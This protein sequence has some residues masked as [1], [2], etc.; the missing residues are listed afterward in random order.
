MKRYLT[1]LITI[2]SVTVIAPAAFSDTGEGS[3]IVTD[4][5]SL[6]GGAG[7]GE[8]GAGSSEAGPDEAGEADEAGPDEDAGL[9]EELFGEASGGDTPFIQEGESTSGIESALLV[10]DGVELGGRY[11]FSASS[12]WEW[13]EP[14][15]LL[16]DLTDP[17]I[18]PADVDFSPTGSAA[19]DLNATLFFD[20]RPSEDFRV[21]GKTSITHPFED[22]DGARSFDEVFHIE[23]L[24]SDFSLN[25]A[26]F[27]RGGKHTIN[28]GVGYF[29]SPAD[30]LNITEIDPE[31]PEADREGPV[32][33]KAQYPFGA[34]NAYLYGIANRVDEPDEFGVAAKVELVFGS[35]EFGAGGL[36]QK[37]IAP[38]AMLTV[39]A[40]LAD[41]DLFAEAVFR[42][43]SDRTFV[44]ESNAPEAGYE[45]VTYDDEL[46]FNATLGFSF[47]HT[48]DEVS[49]SINL[50]G[51]YLFN[52]EGYDDPSIIKEYLG[53]AAAAMLVD[54]D[55]EI[56]LTVSDMRQTG[57][58]YTAL[59]G[60]WNSIFGSDFSFQ[61]LWMH[62][63]SDSSG[64]FSPSISMAPFDQL[65]ISLKTPYRYGDGG[66]EYSPAGESVSIHLSANL[67][68]GR[69]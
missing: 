51:Q 21:F 23:E 25:D 3:G 56:P 49:S 32:S 54:P 59:G 7:D 57:K 40:P 22:D 13:A 14:T 42:Y 16:K 27:F 1:F 50:T 8:G 6:F 26:L 29:F 34:H 38:S 9:E 5:E 62:N 45:L 55:M 15:A 10:S 20:A 28:W 68:S 44:T 60:G 37:D 36:Y 24:F 65:T 43:G 52:G 53:Y 48:F 58:H 30:L 35:M 19:V 2:M 31:D 39:S 61:L 69:Y 12:R 47:L 46:F 11:S 63:Y 33:L 18:D 67:G 17:E 64:W 4:E 66:D 41:V